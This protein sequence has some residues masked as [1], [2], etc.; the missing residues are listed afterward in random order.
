M[1]FKQ[2]LLV[3][4][5]FVATIGAVAIAQQP[6]VNSTLNAVFAVPID[7]KAPTYGA[8]IRGLVPA[9]SATD[10]FTLCGNASNIVR[11]SSV[12]A[13][14]RATAVAGIDVSLVLRTTAN[15]GGTSS[16][17]TIQK[18]DSSFSNA[19]SVVLAYTANPTLGT[20][21]GGQLGMISTKQMFY[22]NLT[23]GLA[24][25]PVEWY[26]GN[27]PAGMPVLRGVAQCLAINLNGQSASGGLFE[28]AVEWMEW[29]N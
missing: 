18:Y 3:G 6:G 24:A 2:A 25:P 27:R 23:T 10:V 8:G 7:N 16:T 5:A 19:S 17:V 26:F 20:S 11:V 13:S 29:T 15:S 28:L 4:L 21:Q 12:V 9:S 1:K 22:G 14:G